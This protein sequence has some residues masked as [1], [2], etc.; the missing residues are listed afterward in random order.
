MG[1]WGTGIFDNDEASDWLDEL[2]TSD[3]TELL[4]D[5]FASTKA[6]DLDAGDGIRILCA[7]A[8]LVVALGRDVDEAPDLL[9]IWAAGLFEDDIVA[10]LPEARTAVL[11]VLADGSEL[12]GL[13]EDSTDYPK[14][15]ATAQSLLD[16]LKQ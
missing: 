1:A 15:E 16:G 3:G 14:W 8:A 6:G 4:A 2:C 12:K 13:W 9:K 10:L 7:A 5:A 11:Q